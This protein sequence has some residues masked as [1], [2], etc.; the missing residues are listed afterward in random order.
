MKKR[1]QQA[2]MELLYRPGT[3][4]LLTLLAAISFQFMIITLPLVGPAGSVAPH[5]LM[6][7]IT[8]L[9]ILLLTMTLSALAFYSKMKRRK[10]DESGF[11]YI[12]AGLLAGTFFFLFALFTGLFAI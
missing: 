4:N 2:N 7:F 12:S 8:Y 11:P 3:G 9:L 6:N 10:I 5:A 1:D